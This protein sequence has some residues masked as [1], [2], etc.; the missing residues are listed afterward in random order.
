[1]SAHNFL[2]G[3]S[4]AEWDALTARIDATL[5]KQGV[6]IPSRIA[7]VAQA[8]PARPAT[9]PTAPKPAAPTGEGFASMSTE[10]LWRIHASIADGAER[11]R[12]FRAQIKPR[13]R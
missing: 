10:Q 13:I 11:T 5:T 8:T 7:I 9:V 3:H 4:R 2:D 12:F 1:M 6:A